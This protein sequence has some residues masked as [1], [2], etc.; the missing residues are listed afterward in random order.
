VRINPQQ[1]V[2]GRPPQSTVDI[3]DRE[4]ELMGNLSLNKELHFIETVNDWIGKY[5][6][7]PKEDDSKKEKD[8]GKENEYKHVTVRTIKLTKETAIELRTSAKFDRS[9]SFI[10]KLRKEG[11]EV[12]NAWLK[13]W[14]Y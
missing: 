11:E 6:W 3:R 10:D 9:R 8:E 2:D 14:P 7:T 5:N 13:G 1:R 4:N 12:G